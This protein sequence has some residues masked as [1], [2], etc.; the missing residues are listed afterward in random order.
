MQDTSKIKE[1][2]L[3]I[4]ERE[5][6]SLPVRIASK[7]ELSSLFTSAFLSELLSDK[8]LKISNLRVGNSPLY[9][10]VGQESQLENFSEHLKSK[11]KEA[12][13]LLQKKR[14]LDD[15]LQEPAIRVA[16]RSIKDFA[17]PF[18]KDGRV[19][20]RY[21]IVPE[22]EFRKD[23]NKVEEEKS[24]K[25]LGEITKEEKVSVESKKEKDVKIVKKVIKKSVRK[26]SSKKN[27]KLFNQVKEFLS[28][29]NIEIVDIE[30]VGQKDLILRISSEGEEKLLVA[31]DKKRIGED[32]IIKANKK[33]DELGLKYMIVSFGE[34]LKKLQGLIEAIR[35]L[36]MIEKI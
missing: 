33:A 31:Y 10:I 5:G 8:R 32:E 12:F 4:V 7:I 27:D 29:K 2:I 36:D 11:E 20:W 34:P 25:D 17:I 3:S 13:L 18:Q 22:S 14:F 21:F 23:V 28:E 19:Y 6:P 15:S 30:G 24:K 35:N 1:R 9:F 26:K 16:L